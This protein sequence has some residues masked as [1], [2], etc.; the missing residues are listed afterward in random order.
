MLTAH[1]E[2]ELLLQAAELKLTK[3]LV[4]PVSRNDLKEA[5]NLAIEEIESYSTTNNLFVKLSNDYKWDNK[6]NTLLYQNNPIHLTKTEST[7]MSL[8][9]A[10]K[11]N[12][13]TYETL[14]YHLWD[15]TYEDRSNALKTAINKL[16]KKIPKDLLDNDYG[17]GYRIN[18][19]LD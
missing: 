2:I 10:Q 11:N 16:R 13:V 1:S 3:Y 19:F 18:T 8:L 6:S 12:V 5:L 7:I 4:K 17:F 9:I 15:E 14:I